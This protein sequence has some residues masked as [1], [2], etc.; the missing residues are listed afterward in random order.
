MPI[1]DSMA[2]M[3]SLVDWGRVQTLTE[4]HCR[5]LFER[6]L[7]RATIDDVVTFDKKIASK[8]FNL[9]AI[10]RDDLFKG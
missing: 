2:Q 6:K 1:N 10:D 8:L 3:R 4:D 9:K 7:Q 5:Q